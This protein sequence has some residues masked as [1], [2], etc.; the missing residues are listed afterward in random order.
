[1]AGHASVLRPLSSGT[2]LYPPSSVFWDRLLSSILRLPALRHQGVEAGDL[3]I[4]VTFARVGRNIKQT[5]A[6]QVSEQAAAPHPMVLIVV[7]GG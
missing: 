3:G 1:M 4:D 5:V 2:V 7:P 6:R